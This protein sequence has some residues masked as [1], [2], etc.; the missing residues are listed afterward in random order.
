MC[1]SS[2]VDNIYRPYVAPADE[3]VRRTRENEAA[4]QG[5]RVPEATWALFF[6]PP[7]SRSHPTSSAACSPPGGRP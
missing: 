7:A 4:M 1:G 2:V 3:V 5:E 6:S